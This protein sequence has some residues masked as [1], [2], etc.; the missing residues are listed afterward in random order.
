M[1]QLVCRY[2]EEEV[3]EMD[4]AARWGCMCKLNAVDP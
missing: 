3:L 2:T 1:G 4:A